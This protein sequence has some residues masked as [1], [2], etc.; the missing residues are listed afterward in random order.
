[1]GVHFY[2]LDS[3]LTNI[4]NRMK[5]ISSL[6]VLALASK[7]NGDKVSKETKKLSSSANSGIPN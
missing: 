3:F 1:M 6:P 5:I 2:P 4:P 7:Y